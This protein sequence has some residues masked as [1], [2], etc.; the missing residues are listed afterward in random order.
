MWGKLFSALACKRAPWKA[1]EDFKMYFFTYETNLPPESGFSIFGT[2]HLL[3]LGG[4]ALAL[5]LLTLWY[6]G[7]SDL[8]HIRL[9]RRLAWLGCGLIVLLY[10]YLALV[11]ELGAGRV[12]LHLCELAPLIYLLFSYTHWD[13]A[14]QVCYALCLP[15]AAAALIFPGWTVYPLW[16]LMNLHGFLLHALLVLFPVWQ[17]VSGAIR[18]RLSALWKPWVFLA[19]V[20]PPVWWFNQTFG[21]NYFFLRAGSPDSPLSVLYDVFGARGYLPAYA[22]LV[23]LVM[24][25]CYLPWARRRE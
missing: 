25:V 9:S 12:P 11:G 4:I 17:L 23:L 13:W 14:G 20:L 16:S 22:A 1:P 6:W 24:L 19:A 2:G 8:D 21:T 18:P 15:G 3:W 10:G 7:Q 5:V